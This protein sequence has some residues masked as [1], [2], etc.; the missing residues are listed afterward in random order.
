MDMTLAMLHKYKMTASESSK[1]NGKAFS[2]N[3]LL[4][5]PWDFPKGGPTAFTRNY[6]TTSLSI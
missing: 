5:F 4:F 1:E 6:S 3:V 2:V